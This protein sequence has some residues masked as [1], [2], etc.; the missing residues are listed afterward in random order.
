MDRPFTL[1]QIYTYD[2]DKNKIYLK[3]IKLIFLLIE[4]LDKFESDS[5]T[6]IGFEQKKF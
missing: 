1:D 2:K 3:K 5:L 4:D 6:T